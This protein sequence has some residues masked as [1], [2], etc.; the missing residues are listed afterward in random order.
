MALGYEPLLGPV[1]TQRKGV[2]IPPPPPPPPPPGPGTRDPLKHPYAS[3][4]P[5][6]LPIG[7]NAVRRPAMLPARP[8]FADPDVLVLRPNAPDLQVFHNNDGWGGGDRKSKQSATPIHTVPCPTDFFVA[9]NR[10]GS[11]HGTTPNYATAFLMRDGRTLAQGQ[12][13]CIPDWNTRVRRSYGTWMWGVVGQDLHGTAMTGS[14]GGSNL[15]N[16]AGTLRLGELA[17]GKHIPH[18]LTCSLDVFANGSRWPATKTDSGGS[19]QVQMGSLLALPLNYDLGQLQSEPGKIF[20]RCLKEYGI[21]VCDNAGWA[22]L[23]IS[24]EYSPDGDVSVVEFPANWQMPFNGGS[25]AWGQDVQKMVQALEII[26]SWN[27]AIWQR[28]AASNGLEG[29][30]G[31]PPVVDWS[32]P[33]QVLPAARAMTVR[34]EMVRGTQMSRREWLAAHGLPRTRFEA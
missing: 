12:P 33:L 4:N 17:P 15:G 27:F 6:N 3:N 23:N 26:D 2:V 18:A 20:G 5:I 16:P 34:P 32:P 31:G 24:T 22:V 13:I 11:P 9:G 14:H 21:Y 8:P 1:V 28:V 19:G 25:S 29:A 10:E 7:R 30:G